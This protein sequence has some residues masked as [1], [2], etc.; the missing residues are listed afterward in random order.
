MMEVANMNLSTANEWIIRS[1]RLYHQSRD[2]GPLDTNRPW[3]K[4]LYHGKC[5]FCRERKSRFSKLKGEVGKE[6]SKM[7]E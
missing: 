2:V 6:I 3:L 5:G 1:V 4:I 7:V